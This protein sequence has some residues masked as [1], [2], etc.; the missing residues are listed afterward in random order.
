MSYY[1]RI[2]SPSPD[3][4]PFK[5]LKETENEFPNS[6]LKIVSKNK[7]G[8]NAIEIKYEKDKPPIVLERNIIKRNSLG[9]K[10]LKEFDKEIDGFYPESAR[11]WLK[12]YFK[13][14]KTIYA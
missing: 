12:A 14:V 2:L 10:E 4:M 5:I 6:S 3:T 7:S 1:V 11:K 13:K 9:E 8:W